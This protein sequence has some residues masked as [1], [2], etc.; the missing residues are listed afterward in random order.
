MDRNHFSG[1]A[2]SR[3]SVLLAGSTAIPTDSSAVTPKSGSV[4]GGAKNHSARSRFSHELEPG[5]IDRALD[6]MKRAG[7]IL[8]Q[9]SDLRDKS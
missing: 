3:L 7:A 4:P 5:D 8:L 1:I 9:S 6:E 2:G